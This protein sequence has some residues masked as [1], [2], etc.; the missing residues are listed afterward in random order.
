MYWNE[1]NDNVE[2]HGEKELDV[3]LHRF[4]GLLQRFGATVLSINHEPDSWE[5]FL[6]ALKVGKTPPY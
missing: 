2:V 3:P 6:Y 4:P 1:I 5:R